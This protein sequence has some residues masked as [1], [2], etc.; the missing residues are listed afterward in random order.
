MVKRSKPLFPW[1]VVQ[2]V[3]KWQPCFPILCVQNYTGI[4]FSLSIIPISYPVNNAQSYN[5]WD[6]RP[7]TR[8][9]SVISTCLWKHLDQYVAS[10]RRSGIDIPAHC[11]D[12]RSEQSCTTVHTVQMATYG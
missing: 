1:G 3:C 6:S 9:P 7:Q 2:L 4:S 5:L 12:T 11:E 10:L 8:V